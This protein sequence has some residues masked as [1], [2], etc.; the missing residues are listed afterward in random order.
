MSSIN[1][2]TLLLLLIIYVTSI[3][4]FS[5]VTSISSSS[6]SA[7]FII[8]SPSLLSPGSDVLPSSSLYCHQSPR[9]W[10]SSLSARCNNHNIININNSFSRT[11]SYSYRRSNDRLLQTTTSL[12]SSAS[13]TIN[14]DINNTRQERI[15][16][17]FTTLLRVLLPAIFSGILAFVSLP[18]ICYYITNFIIKGGQQQQIG[19]LNDAVTSFISLIGLLY[20]ILVGQVF[21]FLYSQQEVSTRFCVRL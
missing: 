18:T 13:A 1:S 14:N 10:S 20:S 8:S 12:Q 16:F 21:G 5:S 4:S 6:S 7:S 2:F 9:R 19:M 11:N 3:A 17:E 15:I